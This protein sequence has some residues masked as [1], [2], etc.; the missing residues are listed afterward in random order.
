MDALL[1]R[2]SEPAPAKS[3]VT[4]ILRDSPTQPLTCHDRCDCSALVGDQ[5]GLVSLGSCGAQAKVRVTMRTGTQIVFCGHH[6][7][8]HGPKI[9]QVAAVHDERDRVEVESSP[10]RITQGAPLFSAT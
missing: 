5:A 2:I 9:T 3:V 7:A 1:R 10:T 8:K 6:Y 4:T